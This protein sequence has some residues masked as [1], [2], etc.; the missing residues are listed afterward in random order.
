VA[1]SVAD[2]PLQGGGL[3]GEGGL[4]APPRLQEPFVPGDDEPPLG[5]LQVDD[6][7]LEHVGDLQHLLGL[8]G[9]AFQGAQVGHRGQQHREGGAD[10][11]REQPAGDQ[12]ATGQPTPVLRPRRRPSRSPQRAHN[13]RLDHNPDL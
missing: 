3:A 6:L 11:Q 12:H 8:A 7:P 5:R 1:T 4:G 10:Q 2:Q 13:R 9:A